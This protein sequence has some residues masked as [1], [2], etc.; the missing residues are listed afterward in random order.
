MR[1]YIVLAVVAFVMLVS[2]Y[3]LVYITFKQGEDQKKY[4]ADRGMVLVQK[5]ICVQGEYVP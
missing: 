2:L 5:G 4:C 1:K 3:T